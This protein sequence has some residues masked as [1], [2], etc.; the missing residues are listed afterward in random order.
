MT[1]Y[2]DEDSLTVESD[3]MRP[4]EIKDAKN[5][6]ATLA[7]VPAALVNVYVQGHFEIVGR[8]PMNSEL[9]LDYGW[10]KVTKI[11]R[12]YLTVYVSGES[13][14][15]TVRPLRWGNRRPGFKLTSRIFNALSFSYK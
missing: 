8:E 3:F 10:H 12:K 9:N 1:A 5:A 4:S 13:S 11:G 14:H 7:G 15:F 6:L 2:V